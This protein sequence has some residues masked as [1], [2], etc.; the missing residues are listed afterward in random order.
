MPIH[1]LY[2]DDEDQEESTAFSERV[3]NLTPG[4]KIHFDY[5]SEFTKQIKFIE[6][7]KFNEDGLILDLRLDLKAHEVNGDK[8]QADYRA[9][10]LAQEVRTRAAET[11]QGEFPI[12]LWS[13]DRRLKESY[14]RD[15][16]SH[17]LFDLTVVK[18]ELKDDA[19]A[20]EVGQQLL[21]LV[22]GYQTIA[23]IRNEETRRIGWFY[24]IL[25]FESEEEASFLDT[26]LLEH[27]DFSELTRPV[28]EYARFIIHHLLDVPGPLIDRLMLASRL[29]LDL[30]GS[31]DA[32]ALIKKHFS[33]AKYKGPFGDGWER[34]WAFLVEK[35]WRDLAHDARSLRSLNAAERVERLKAIGLK[36]LKP[37]EPLNSDYSTRFWTICQKLK[38]PLDPRDGLLLNREKVYPWQEEQ[39]V[40]FKAFEQR[41]KVY[42]RDI[43]P[44]DRG[45]LD[46]MKQERSDSSGKN[47]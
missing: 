21:S 7:E 38:R 28:Q 3:E 16:T 12:V 14:R 47:E 34:W 42:R 22:R 24:R 32:E 40:S 35:K 5:P 4:L 8:K 29:G 37:A 2:L 25:G 15:Q 1:Y 17:D 11:R 23:R 26:R 41:L 33:K 6:G 31:A 39:F 18:D 9:P 20:R 46:R 44:I 19:R 13:F 10:S 36:G 45:R 27:F 30:S 43:S